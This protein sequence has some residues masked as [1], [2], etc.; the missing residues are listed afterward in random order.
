MR[1]AHSGIA[2]VLAFWTIACSPVVT[3]HTKAPGVHIYGESVTDGNG[4]FVK[5]TIAP[6]KEG[7]QWNVEFVGSNPEDLKVSV[8]NG[9]TRLH[10]KLGQDH[11]KSF[12]IDPYELKLSSGGETFNVRV[13]F[14]TP[15]QQIVGGIIPLLISFL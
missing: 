15:S 9:I 11:V 13:N 1:D 8:D 12:G 4:R 5:V 7:T 10:W 3:T 6:K 2:T 14:T